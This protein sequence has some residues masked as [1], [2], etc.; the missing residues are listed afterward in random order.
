MRLSYKTKTIRLVNEMLNNLDKEVPDVLLAA[1][2]VLASQ[3]PRLDAGERSRFQSPLATA[4]CLDHQGNLTF[5]P[6]H[7]GG[8]VALVRLKGG[9]HNIKML[10]IADVIGL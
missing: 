2:L 1:V 6:E 9:L 7:A 4:Q 10:G 5:E 3:G 8:M